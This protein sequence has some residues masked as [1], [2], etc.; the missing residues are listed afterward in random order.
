MS[1]QVEPSRQL[2]KVDVG[3]AQSIGGLANNN[4]VTILTRTDRKRTWQ[5]PEELEYK[6]T[7]VPSRPLLQVRSLKPGRGTLLTWTELYS[8]P[9]GFE[10]PLN[11]GYVQLADDSVILAHGRM[12][13]PFRLDGT[14]TVDVE[15]EHFVFKHRD[16]TGEL[17]KQIS[18]LARQVVGWWSAV[19]DVSTGAVRD[20]KAAKLKAARKKR[21]LESPKE[22]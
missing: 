10:V 18:N 16:T 9:P 14:V 22:G 12:E 15:G 6:P 4:L 2:S 5:V 17:I 20:R 3:L 1:G 8:P 7:L 19:E 13:P 21:Q 11:L